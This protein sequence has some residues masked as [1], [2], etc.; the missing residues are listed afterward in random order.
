MMIIGV[1]NSFRSDDG[2][3]LLVARQ[4]ANQTDR[5]TIREASGEGAGLMAAWE[6]IEHVILIDAV[7]SGAEPGTIFRLDVHERPVPAS[8]FHYSTHD[9]G[10]AEAVE[11]GRVLG[12]LPPRLIIYGIEGSN[13]AFGEGLSPPVAQAVDEVVARVLSELAD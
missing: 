13:F 5:A 2:I 4:L 7:S 3:G 9:F 11:M 12:Q 8:F 1:G 10:V 6:G